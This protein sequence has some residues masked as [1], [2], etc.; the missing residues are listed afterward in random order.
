[1]TDLIDEPLAPLS[2]APDPVPPPASL[3][4]AGGVRRRLAAARRAW[5]VLTSMRTALIL[6]AML[7]LAAVPGTLLPQ[8]GLNPLR[9]ADFHR[10]HPLLAPWLDRLSLFDVF[11]APW[12]AA[13]YLLLFVSLIGCLVSRIR[14]HARALRT[15]PPPAPRRLSRLPAYERFVLPVEPDLALRSATAALRRRRF[16]VRPA[17]DSVA[18]EKGYLRETGN[19]VFHVALV[20]L[21][22][23][24]ALGGLFGYKGTVIVPEGD[25]F[26]DTLAS[27]DGFSPGR[28]F[29]AGQLAPWSVTLE[30]FH[31]FYQATGEPTSFDAAVKYRLRVDGP[32]RSADV[33][34]NHP[35]ALD[36]AT[37]Y[38]VGHGYAPRFVVRDGAGNVA[39]EAATPFLPDDGNF[40]S[41][42][43]VKAPDALPRQLGFA[44]LFFPTLGVG[45]NG[46]VSTFPG[47]ARPF[48]LL[49]AYRGD[50]GLDSGRPQS[51]YALDTSHLT[52]LNSALLAPGQ[53]MRL[54][55]GGSIT[56]AGVSQYAT[57]QVGHD[58]GSTVALGAG[59]L[60]IAGLLGSLWVRRRRVWVRVT[61]FVP[62]AGSGPDGG[63]GPDAPDRPLRSGTPP[64]RTVIEVGGLA[65]SDAAGF[66]G[67]FARIVEALKEV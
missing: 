42:G 31:A 65:R 48:V 55:G 6:L 38:L 46:L 53:T 2:T 49:T 28:L 18:A 56:F 14:L 22:V 20:G 54:T 17:D 9:V 4:T 35:L 25:G 57:F 41:H 58:P 23:G 21:L 66:A 63:S 59:V 26:A 44:G 39:Y 24:V 45:P 67:E 62:D 5:R 30:S 15:P 33:R 27:Y 37:L 43:V 12:F 36:G 8:R 47:A 29:S 1:M 10:A 13:I 19:L 51:V 40:S 7:A 3:P 32:V 16:R 64:G 11:S 61:R 52:R 50:L 34:V 60:I